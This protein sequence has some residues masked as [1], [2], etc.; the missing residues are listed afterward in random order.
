[1]VNGSKNTS[2]F[3]YGF[4]IFY[5]LVIGSVLAIFGFSLIELDLGQPQPTSNLINRTINI[6]NMG[7][8]FPGLI[9]ELFDSEGN[10]YYY[11]QWF[12]HI[13]G[14]GVY[15]ITFY[16]NTDGN[17]QIYNFVEITP[18]TVDKAKCIFVNGVCQ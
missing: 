13:H 16:C 14:D 1:M 9:N 12:K 17:R 11:I 15:N 2:N 3:E 4:A 5:V 8:A 7:P 10:G 18:P 6:S